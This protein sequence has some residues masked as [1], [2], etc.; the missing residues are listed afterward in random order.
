MAP[1]IL[2]LA[3]QKG[4]VGKTTTAINLATALAAIGERVLIV[5][6]DPQ[7]NASTGLGIGRADRDVSSYDVIVGQ[8][9][10]ARAAVQTSVPN[11]VLIPSTMDLAGVELMIAQQSDRTFKLRDAFRALDEVKI[12][13]Q[14]VSY[15]LIDCPPSL[16]LLTINALVAAD[17]VL[18]PLQ[19]EF[20][21]LEGL[22]QLLQTIEHIRTTLNPRLSIQGI[23]MTMFDKRN[24]L[25]GQVLSDVRSELG[26]LVYDTVIPRNV[27]LSEAPSYGKPALLYDLQCAGSQAYLRLATEVIRRERH[28]N[29]A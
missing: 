14:P 6:L 9:G 20:F 7:G 1:R 18:V 21:A 11:V 24:N 28:L 27:R 25:S 2:T 10:V 12:D 13:G 23:V 29:A 15:V 4:G 26:D 19:C 16:N 8:A 17:A 22:S 3:N 5:D